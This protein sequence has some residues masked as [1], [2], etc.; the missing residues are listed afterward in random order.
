VQWHQL[1][2]RW[3]DWLALGTLIPFWLAR[4][5]LGGMF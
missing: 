4:F 2:L 1:K 5:A 3:R